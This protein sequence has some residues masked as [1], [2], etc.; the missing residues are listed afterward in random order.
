MATTIK[1]IRESESYSPGTQRSI[2][3]PA[4]PLVETFNVIG[5]RSHV[6]DNLLAVEGLL[7]ASFSIRYLQQTSCQCQPFTGDGGGGALTT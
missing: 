6:A 4:L 7:P 2:V 1:Q 5:D 3:L